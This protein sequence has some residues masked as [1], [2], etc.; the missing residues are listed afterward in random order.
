MTKTVTQE[1]GTEEQ[2]QVEV[3]VDEN[4]DQI[5]D[6]EKAGWNK[7]QENKSTNPN[8]SN[9]TNSP[10]ISNKQPESPK[11]TKASGSFMARIKMRDAGGPSSNLRGVGMQRSR[12]MPTLSDQS[13]FPTLG[14]ATSDKPVA[15][16]TA[17]HSGKMTGGR[18]GSMEARGLNTSNRFGGLGD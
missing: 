11:E 2:Q 6:T 9:A 7:T 1:D 13:A 15:G 18:G 8:T 3:E 14:N 16:F 12:K 5:E 4:G 17:V 10:Q